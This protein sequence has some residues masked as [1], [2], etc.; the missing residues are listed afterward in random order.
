MEENIKTISGIHYKT[1]EQIK[2]E[3]KDGRIISIKNDND[4][5]SENM[6]APGFVDIQINGYKGFDFNESALTTEEWRQ[7]SLE[8]L[9]VG[10]TTYYPT[11]ITNSI[12]NLLTLLEENVK[13]IN[14]CELC[15][16]VIGGFHLEGP[17][18]SKVDGPRGAHDKKYVKAPDFE[19]F[20]ILQE[21][22]EGYIKILTMSPE[23]PNSSEFIAKVSREG[24]V[25]AIGHTAAKTEEIKAAVQSGA[26]LSTHFGNGAHVELPRHPNYLWDQLAE[27][28]LW[29][30]VIS[31][32][33][34]LPESVLKVVNKV[35]EEKMI[36]IS[37]SVALA[38]LQAGEYRAKVGGDVILTE[39][40]RLHLKSNPNLLA[41]SAQNLLEGV[42]H[43]QRK[44]FADFSVGIDKASILPAKL[45][46]LP[47]KAGL[48]VGAPANLLVFKGDKDDLILDQTILYGNIY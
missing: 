4:G 45:M 8:L 42:R 23:W 9:R 43:F 17:Y 16:D 24:V 18:I 11:F 48:S 46:N 15:K 34:H 30:S 37:D 44:N 19:E 26:R 1:K 7:V 14:K 5:T 32:G 6:I 27:D 25:V 13:A 40:G 35:K 29:C 36:L 31:D 21:A 28:Q 10:V 22:A 12:V 33:H 47:Q 2:I 3:I 41:G 20:L 39:E 38:G